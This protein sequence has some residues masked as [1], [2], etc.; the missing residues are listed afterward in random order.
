MQ[1]FN[2][3]KTFGQI[4]ICAAYLLT[5]GNAAIVA[6]WICVCTT[7]SYAPQGPRFLFEGIIITVTLS[8][9]CLTFIR[10]PPKTTAQSSENRAPVVSLACG[11]A[12]KRTDPCSCFLFLFHSIRSHAQLNHINASVGGVEHVHMHCR[13]KLRLRRKRHEENFELWHYLDA[14]FRVGE[15][16]YMYFSCPVVVKLKK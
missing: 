6:H 9:L 4:I 13:V 14:L 12:R 1:P 2:L 7:N 11:V 5:G 3:P 15:H 10:P 8:C 16:V